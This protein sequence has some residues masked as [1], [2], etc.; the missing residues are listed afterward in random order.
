[1]KWKSAVATAALAAGIPA[2]AGAQGVGAFSVDV[3]A[4]ADT[5]VS[6]PF[7]NQPFGE[8]EVQSVSGNTATLAGADFADAFPA[9]SQGNASYYVRFTTGA[10][11]GRWFNIVGQDSDSVSLNIEDTGNPADLSSVD[12]GDEL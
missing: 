8:F 3:P 7:A 2:V 10:L 5:R 1:M 11:A 9:N 6:V 12:P 4:Q